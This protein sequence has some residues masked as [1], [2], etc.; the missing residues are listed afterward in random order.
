M[1]PHSMSLALHQEVAEHTDHTDSCMGHHMEEHTV[2]DGDH[3]KVVSSVGVTGERVGFELD[4]E[5]RV[6]GISNS[7]KFAAEE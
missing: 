3:Q 7:G 4:F 6:T 5:Q 1:D 2:E